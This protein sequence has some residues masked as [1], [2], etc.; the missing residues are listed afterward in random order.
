[1]LCHYRRSID[2]HHHQRRRSLSWS[3]PFFFF[4]FFFFLFTTVNIM[5]TSKCDWCQTGIRSSG[6]S[7]KPPKMFYERLP[8]L[9]GGKRCWIGI[10]LIVIGVC[11]FTLLHIVGRRF[12]GGDE[13]GE[14]G[15]V[16]KWCFEP[17]QP[18]RIISGLETNISPSPTYSAQ[19]SWKH[20]IL[21]NPQNQSWHKYKPQHPNI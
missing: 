14:G 5:I 6:L 17:S 19:K 1:M 9:V 4:S 3:E 13:T 15:G 16:D 20:K 21:H 11:C 7:G 2:V 10:S 18:Q 12:D 8:L